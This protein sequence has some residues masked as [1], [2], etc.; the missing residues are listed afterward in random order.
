VTDV[1]RTRTAVIG[2]VV[3]AAATAGVV[4]AVNAGS[5]DAADDPPAATTDDLKLTSV[6][7]RDLKRETTLDGTVGRGTP[8]PLSIPGAGTLTGLPAVGD[9]VASGQRLAEVDGAPVVLLT[10]ERPAW[11]D[12]VPGIDDGEDIRQLEQALTDLGYA[13]SSLEVDDE[14][15]SATTASVKAFQKAIGTTQD[16]KLSLG[17]IVF[18]PRTVR[19][20]SVE[21]NTGDDVGT[22]GIETTGEAQVIEADADASDA[23]IIAPGTTV[24]IELPTGREVAGT[25]YT[26]G[27]PTT[28]DSGDTTLPVVVVADGLDAIDGLGVDIDISTVDVAGATAVPAEALLALSEGGYALEVP[29]ASSAT[30]TRLVAV[31]LGAFDEDGWVQVTGDVAPGDQVVVP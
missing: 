14:W 29:D 2:V 27:A 7:Q 28:D 24:T 13:T 25:V 11:R 19:I 20:A 12:L 9:T 3:L 18:A 10:G 1:R 22:A 30:G 15:T 8:S 4:V 26:V 16:G 31:E 5:S 21:G 17:E 23:D 6:E